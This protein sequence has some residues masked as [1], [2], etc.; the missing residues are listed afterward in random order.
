MNQI[1]NNINDLKAKL[2]KDTTSLYQ[3]LYLGVNKISVSELTWKDPLASQIINDNSIIIQQLPG[4]LKKSF[5]V[6][7]FILQI[8]SIYIL[9]IKLTIFLY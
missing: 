7:I 8:Q 6:S 5:M 2:G 1:E 3:H 4:N 9:E